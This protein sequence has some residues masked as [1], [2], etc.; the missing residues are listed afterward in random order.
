MKI[1]WQNYLPKPARL[2]IKIKTPNMIIPP[3]NISNIPTIV[4]QKQFIATGGG[5]N[6]KKLDI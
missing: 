6:F 4:A 2:R 5:E 3:I 1:S